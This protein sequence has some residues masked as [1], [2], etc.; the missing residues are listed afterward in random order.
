MRLLSALFLGL[1]LA[2][3]SA[4]AKD[5]VQFGYRGEALPLTKLT[6]LH[7][8]EG[9]TLDAFALRAGVWFRNFTTGSSYEACGPVM[10]SSQ[11]EGRWAIP[12]FSNL[13]QLGCAMPE[14]VVEGFVATGETIHSH[15]VEKVVKPNA[16]DRVFVAGQSNRFNA[17]RRQRRTV[18]SSKFSATDFASGAGYLVAD[19]KVFYQNGPSSVRQVGELP[20]EV[21]VEETGPTVAQVTP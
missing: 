5:H 13:S 2:A 3:G 19:N 14:A 15:P 7:S 20:A 9:E 4:S 8:R 11:E 18:D 21:P 10:V 1:A 6:T 16:R 12:V 17:E